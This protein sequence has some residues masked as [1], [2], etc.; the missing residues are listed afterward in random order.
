MKKFFIISVA[1]VCFLFSAH[2]ILAAIGVGVGTGKIQI[3]DPLKPGMIYEI[4]PLTVSNTGDEPGEY[5][6]TI[7][8]HEKQPE[9]RPDKKWFLFSPGRFSLEPGKVQ[10]VREKIDLPVNAQPGDYFA[11][12]EAH[13]IK[14]TA[15]GVTSINI[16]AASKLYFTVV[17]ASTW[18]G[19]YYKAISLWR[20]YSPYTD[21]AG[22]ALLLF[23]VGLLIRKFIHIDVKLKK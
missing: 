17:P 7:Q 11:Y 18:Q 13:P 9:L 19:I 14:S 8:Y 10:V 6:V 16:A 2:V 15:Q 23:G 1:S 4:T 22:I 12:L 21:I 3:N 20:L 5:E